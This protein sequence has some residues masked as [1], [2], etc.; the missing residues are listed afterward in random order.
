MYELNGQLAREAE[1]HFNYLDK[2]GKYIGKFT[3]AEK[4]VSTKKGTHGIGFTFETAEK[5]TTRFDLWT[6]GSDNTHLMGMKA[7]NAVMACMKIRS[8]SPAAGKVEK[9]DFDTRKMHT[10]DAQI[11][12]ELMGKPIGLVMRNTEYEKM[13]DG[14]GTGQTGWRLEL[15]VPFN[16]ETEM[17]A[18]EVLDRKIKPE[19][20]PIIVETLTDKPMKSRPVAHSSPPSYADDGYGASGNMPDNFDPDIPF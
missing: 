17:T 12:P 10:V 18:S 16:A 9:Y 20:L 4:L 1:N 3:R 11:F 7:L 13:K 15:Y 19:K 14:R 8:I 5:Q 2:T 6:M